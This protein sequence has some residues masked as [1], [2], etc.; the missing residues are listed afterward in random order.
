MVQL[1][2]DTFTRRSLVRSSW[3]KTHFHARS[4]GLGIARARRELAGSQSDGW[5]WPIDP[6]VRPPA[7]KALS[8]VTNFL[9]ARAALATQSIVVRTQYTASYTSNCTFPLVDGQGSIHLEEELAVHI[10][11][12]EICALPSEEGRKISHLYWMK[13]SV[14]PRI[15]KYEYMLNSSYPS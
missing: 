3:D 5:F 9:R 8:C 15:Y 1:I 7:R 6:S 4:I 13:R 2:V 14:R 11:A 12:H 10:S